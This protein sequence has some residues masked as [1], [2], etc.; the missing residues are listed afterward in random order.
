MTLMT[1]QRIKTSTKLVTDLN[2]IDDRNRELISPSSIG[3]KN[4]Q[5]FGEE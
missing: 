4:N 5:S 1:T 2:R 3:R